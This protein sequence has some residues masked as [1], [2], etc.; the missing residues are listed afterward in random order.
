MTGRGRLWVCLLLCSATPAFAAGPDFTRDVRPVLARRCFKCH[1][2][3]DKTR[4]AGLRLDDRAEA[5]AAKAII[6]GRPDVS[7]FVKRI[8][9]TDEG[10][11]MP[12]PHVRAPLTAAEK[13]CWPCR[14]P[15]APRPSGTGCC[16]TSC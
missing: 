16:G 4:E 10:E 5:I 15:D 9:S 11:V 13:T 14:R 7:E 2:P 12:P 1:G 6:P 3:D 8:V